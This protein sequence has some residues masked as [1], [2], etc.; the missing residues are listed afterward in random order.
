MSK[1]V[2]AIAFVLLFGVVVAAIWW[3]VSQTSVNPL[4]HSDKVFVISKGD[5]VREIAKKLHDQ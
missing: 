1:R 4:D 2:A 5:G 3:N